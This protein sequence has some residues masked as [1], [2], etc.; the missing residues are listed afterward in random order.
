MCGKVEG[1]GVGW[2]VGSCD[3]VGCVLERRDVMSEL[4]VQEDTIHVYIQ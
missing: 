4:F 2:G 3:I 1:G